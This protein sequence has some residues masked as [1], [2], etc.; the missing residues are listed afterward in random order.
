MKAW[1]LYAQRVSGDTEALVTPLRDLVDSA[2]PCLADPDLF[3]PATELFSDVLS[4]YSSFFT[5]S[6]YNSFTVLFAS[7]WAQERYRQLLRGE[8]EESGISFGLLMLAYG[9][10]KVQDL[11]ESLDDH[12]QNFLQG[13]SGLLACEG[14]AVG[15]DQMF[16]PA[17][18]F[19][20]T[21]VETMIDSSFS[22][23]GK[24][25]AWRPRAEQHLR[26]VMMNC[27]R[28]I[29]WPA[30]EI[31]SDWDATERAGFGE[32]RKDV[33]DLL[34]SVYTLNGLN[35]LSSFADLLF[36]YLP[37]QA[38]AEAEASIFCLSS[39]SDCVSDNAQADEILS[40]V[41][42]NPLFELLSQARGPIPLRL[43]QTGLSLI[44]RYSEYFERHAEHLPSALNILFDAVGDPVLGGPS[45]RSISRLCSSC[46]SRL[47]GEAGSFIGHYQIIYTGP[48]IDALAE[49]RIVHAIACIIQ[50]IPHEDQRL[51][52]FS[53]LYSSVKRDF[54]EAVRI[55]TRPETV[56]ASDPA[57]LRALD[58][59]NKDSSS[60]D[61]LSLQL[62]LRGMR[63]LASIAKGMQDVT[64]HPIDLDGD[65]Q[66]RQ[67]SANMAAVQSDIMH[68]VVGIQNTFNTSGEM[69]SVICGILRSGFSEVALGPFVFPPEVITE[70]LVKQAFETP[71]LGTFISTACSFVGSLYR[72]PKASV[73]TYLATLLPWVLSMIQALPCRFCIF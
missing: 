30:V 54:E 50:A 70:Y 45:A 19:W 72:G 56:T 8:H 32:A 21:F 36:Q 59:A 15:E 13:L 16:V 25:P 52:S 20:S 71:S 62:A 37:D 23:D 17:L 22:D 68:L 38:W 35:L 65:N 39:L 11:M 67:P 24:M 66:A 69:V 14:Y 12:S 40:K 31:I 47:T 51:Q 7:S 1:I 44:E 9:D 43:R 58:P 60:H 55:K 3:G 4:N 46:R 42:T 28:K 49:E 57:V 10:A 2:M 5:E 27:W 18:E 53:Q 64:E 48:V 63:C 26:T 29:Q 73:P 61:A 34:E 6:H 33:A 41:F